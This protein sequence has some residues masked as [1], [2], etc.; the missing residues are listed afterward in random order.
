MSRERLAIERL[1]TNTTIG[2]SHG[3]ELVSRVLRPIEEDFE[4]IKNMCE[5]LKGGQCDEH[6][7]TTTDRCGLHVHI[8]PD[9]D[10]FDLLTLQH[11]AYILVMYEKHI[12]TLQPKWRRVIQNPPTNFLAAFDFCSN[13]LNFS[14]SSDPEQKHC[15]IDTLAFDRNKGEW[16]TIQRLDDLAAL[17]DVREVIGTTGN[18]ERLSELM[19]PNGANGKGCAVNFENLK[20][21]RQNQALGPRTI[22][23]RQHDGCLNGRMIKYWTIFCMG[24]VR[25]AN[26]MAHYLRDTDGNPVTKFDDQCLYYPWTEWNDGMSI[27]DLYTMMRLPTPA[28]A[29]FRRRAAYNAFR[30]PSDD[31]GANFEYLSTIGHH[32]SPQP[33]SFSDLTGQ[34]SDDDPQPDQGSNPPASSTANESLLPTQSTNPGPPPRRSIP[35][36]TPPNRARSFHTPHT[37]REIAKTSLLH[38][39]PTTSEAHQPHIDLQPSKTHLPTTTTTTHTKRESTIPTSKQAT[40]PTQRRVS[41]LRDYHPEMYPPSTETSTGT[42]TTTDTESGVESG[43]DIGGTSY[44]APTPGPAPVANMV[45]VD[46]PLWSTIMT[47]TGKTVEKA[48]EKAKARSQARTRIQTEKQRLHWKGGLL[49]ETEDVRG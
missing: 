40:I 14:L 1:Y 48:V 23:F 17:R 34:R 30:V 13:S 3:I 12:D 2:D 46:H 8:K 15:A 16:R 4:E 11:L 10:D 26:H 25:L 7:A 33:P 31:D 29:Y 41:G 21:G 20:R 37:P 43:A 38:R 18:V 28:R 49:P 27:E 44:S 45:A 19:C 36:T 47:T 22:E 24:L 35:P 39:Q 9:G 42:S 6:G 5:K 32:H